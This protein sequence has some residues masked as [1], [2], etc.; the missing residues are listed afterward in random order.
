[1]NANALHSIDNGGNPY[2]CEAGIG[3]Q[4]AAASSANDVNEETN[5]CVEE[6]TLTYESF[7]QFIATLTSDLKS[8]EK[9]WFTRKTSP[10]VR[11]IMRPHQTDDWKEWTH[12]FHAGTGD[13]AFASVA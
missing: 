7:D 3:S 4:C 8:L 12:K 2:R 11:D 10:A 1:M 9:S 6:D 5:A 13:P